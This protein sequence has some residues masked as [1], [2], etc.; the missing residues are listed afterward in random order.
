MR[1]WLQNSRDF[2]L[3]AREA[4]LAISVVLLYG[5]AAP[6][7][8]WLGGA[9]SLLAATGAGAVCLLASAL[10]LA[11][12][13]L[14]RRPALAFYGLL[15]AMAVRTGIPLLCALVIRLHGT[16]LAENGFIYYLVV[17]YLVTL[18]IETSLSLPRAGAV[19]TCAQISK[20]RGLT[21]YD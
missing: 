9:A 18:G 19:A 12:S 14:L 17:F 7:A 8:Y 2:N 4:L 5:L 3:P 21:T 10:A 20:G 16:P 15:A 11:L 13:T 6:L 1:N